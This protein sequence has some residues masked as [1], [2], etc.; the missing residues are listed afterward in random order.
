MYFLL[1]LLMSCA[2]SLHAGSRSENVYIE[3]DDDDIWYGPGFYYGI[4]FDNEDDYR[5]WCRDHP[6]RPPSRQYYNRDHPVPYQHEEHG[7]GGGHGHA[8]GGGGHR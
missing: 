3:E 6:N 4:W 5:G 1:V 2:C 8:G 7:E